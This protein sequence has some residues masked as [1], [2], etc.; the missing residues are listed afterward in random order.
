MSGLIDYREN[1]PIEPSSL[2]SRKVDAVSNNRKDRLAFDRY[3]VVLEKK[4]N[5]SIMSNK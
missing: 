5:N 1:N 2:L 3:L 4:F